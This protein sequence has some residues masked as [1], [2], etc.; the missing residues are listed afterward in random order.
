[1]REVAAMGRRG[2]GEGSIYQHADG[3][4]TALIDLGFEN[5]NRK[6]KQLYGKTQR[7]VREQLTAVLREKDRGI[8]L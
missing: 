2:H 3:R 5:S 8:G 1:L 7:E 4:W 6:R